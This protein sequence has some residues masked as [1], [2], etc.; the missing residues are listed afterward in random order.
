M[1]AN[2]YSNRCFYIRDCFSTSADHTQSFGISQGCPLS[3]FLFVILMSVLMHDAVNMTRNQFGIE[4][5]PTLVCHAILYA[6]DTLLVE[7]EKYYLQVFMECVMKLGYTYGL[8]LNWDKVE[9]MPIQCECCL[10]NEFGNPITQKSVMKYLGS[11]IA[12]NGVVSSDL[13]QKEKDWLK[14]ISRTYASCG[15]I[16]TCHANSKPKFTQHAF[17]KDFCMDLMALFYADMII[18]NLTLFMPDALGRSWAFLRHISVVLAISS[19]CKACLPN[20]SA[21]CCGKGNFHFWAIFSNYLT[22]IR[23]VNVFSNRKAWI[24]LNMMTGALAD[25]ETHGGPV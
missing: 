18:K 25:L 21:L 1:V 5:S 14:R 3:P 15:I 6:D 23:S 8:Q 20:H 12:A 22:M 7:A 17:Y 13:V 10:H 2:I 4:L 16:R 9:C 11:N 19:S 24:L